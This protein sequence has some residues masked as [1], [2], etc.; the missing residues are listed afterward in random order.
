MP[1]YGAGTF[2]TFLLV[3]L[4]EDLKVGDCARLAN[5]YTPDYTISSINE[6]K[7]TAVCVWFDAKKRKTVIE[8][9]PLG[10]LEKYTPPPPITL[11]DMKSALGYR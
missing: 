3:Y 11:D 1:L 2:K 10:V 5:G 7:Q 8:E 4:M 6:E 9:I